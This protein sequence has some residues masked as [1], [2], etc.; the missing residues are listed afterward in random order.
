MPAQSI[1]PSQFIT[2][3]GPGSILEGPDGPRIVLGLDHSEVFG[4]ESPSAYAIAEAGLSALLP[5]HPTIVRLPSNA[6]RRVKDSDFIYKTEAFPKWSLCVDHSYLYRYATGTND[7]RTGCPSC[8]P[9]PTWGEAWCRSR[10]EAVRF[11]MA[12]IRGMA[13]LLAGGIDGL[14]F[15]GDLRL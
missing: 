4:T 10:R 1:R 8:A 6:E 9:L 14:F 5:D 2:T 3:Y 11:V 12:E 13:L 15:F 7:R